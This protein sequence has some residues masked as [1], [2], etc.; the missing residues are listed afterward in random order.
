MERVKVD[1]LITGATAFMCDV[2]VP[3]VRLDSQQRFTKQETIFV[4]LRTAS[5]VEGMGYSYTIG[6]GGA[7]VLDLLRNGLLDAAVGM[8]IDRP[9]QIWRTLYN[10]TRATSIGAITSLALA[11]VD[12]AVWDARCRV[13]QLP[14]WQAAGGRNASVPVY[15]TE[16]G[17]LNLS[18]DELVE[19]AVQ[20]KD[21]GMRGIK[22][23]IGKARAR[24]DVER[25]A[26]VRA[27]LGD[28]V[29]IMVDANQAFTVGEAVRRAAMLEP[30]DIFWFEEPLP[31]DDIS[32]HR[33]LAES[34][35]IPIAVGE[36]LYS[37]GQIAEYLRQGAASVIQADAARVGGITPWLKAAHLAEA[38]NVKIAPHFLME[39]HLSLLG[40]VDNALYL[41]HIPQLGAV[42]KAPITITDGEA[43]MPSEPGLGIEWDLDELDG[44]RVG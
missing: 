39:L 31:A 3:T 43:S 14:L 4:Q 34:T 6:T 33:R 36:S 24:E 7:A 41:E 29:D 11:A 9:E 26:A 20:S 19:Q 28:D 15:D 25:V 38:H 12:T 37:I 2:A 1:S 40:A 23:K 16:G 17:W 44:R 35:T 22:M 32:G 10:T 8:D 5:G 21:K 18:V 30:Y 42:T 13:H 27:A